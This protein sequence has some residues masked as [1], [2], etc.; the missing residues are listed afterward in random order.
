MMVALCLL[1]TL[2]FSAL[3]VWQLERRV[4]K[5]ALIEQV[6]RR[7]HAPPVAVPSP[8]EWR[9]FDAKAHAYTRVRAVGTFRHDRETRVDAL[10]ERGAGTWLITPLVTRS[11]TILVNR[12]FVPQGASRLSRPEG[13]LSVVGLLRATE[14]HGRFLRPNELANDRWFSRDVG[15]IARA[16]HLGRVAP[17][18]IDAEA[19]APIDTLPIGGM[20][21]VRFRNAHLSYALTW[22]ALAG[23]SLVGLVIVV[24]SR[25]PRA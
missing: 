22:F 19:S 18:F 6:D 25:H 10:T 17:F 20:T 13:T 2:L 3:G 12:G 24:R 4:W 23:L 15:A 11:G 7:I 9:T 8:N 1:F 5:L 16:R 14:P 21:V